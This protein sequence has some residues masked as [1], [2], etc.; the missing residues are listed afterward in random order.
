MAD[1]SLQ[2]PDQTCDRVAR[3]RLVR[4]VSSSLIGGGRLFNTL[5]SVMLYIVVL[6]N[7]V[8]MARSDYFLV[9]VSN[10]NTVWL[11]LDS[12]PDMAQR[13]DSG[14][15]RP[16]ASWSCCEG[17]QYLTSYVSL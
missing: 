15:R 3:C 1:Q 13:E 6:T 10:G 7:E 2:W 12:V 17:N 4:Y 9:L 14:G 11:W 16:V 5:L 8:C